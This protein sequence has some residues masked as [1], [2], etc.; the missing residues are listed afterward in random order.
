MFWT[1]QDW[2]DSL[3]DYKQQLENELVAVQEQLDGLKE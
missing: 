1:E 3:L 2:K